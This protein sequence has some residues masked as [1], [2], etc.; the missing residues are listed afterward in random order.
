MISLGSYAGS[1]GSRK[2]LPLVSP[3][4]D[5]RQPAA[6]PQGIFFVLG[7]MIGDT[8]N[9]RVHFSATEIFRGDNLAGCSAPKVVRPVNRTVAFDDNILICHGGDIRT[10]AVHMPRTTAT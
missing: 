1:S 6:D 2:S 4:R 3:S 7:E 5:F 10:A 9:L 8:R